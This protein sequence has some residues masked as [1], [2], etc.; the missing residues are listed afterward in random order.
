MQAAW[1]GSLAVAYRAWRRVC[2]F[3]GT[4]SRFEMTPDKKGNIDAEVTDAAM[5]VVSFG[6]SYGG[7]PPHMRFKLF[8]GSNLVPLDRR[9]ARVRYAPFASEQM[10]L[11][12]RR[13][14]FISRAS[15]AS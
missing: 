13:S 14:G 5:R 4:I 15:V 10:Q 7:W 3:E 12:G 1:P 2:A 8:Q 6:I 9:S 11:N